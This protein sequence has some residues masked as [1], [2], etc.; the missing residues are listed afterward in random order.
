[1][2]A[3]LL[4]DESGLTREVLTGVTVIGRSQQAGFFVPDQYASPNHAIIAP[5]GDGWAIA[6]LGSTNGTRVNDEKICG[7]LA[8]ARG[9]KIRIGRT[10]LIAVPIT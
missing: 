4:S 9:D 7:A 8:L 5:R 1:M 3:L 10:T 2:S 6:D